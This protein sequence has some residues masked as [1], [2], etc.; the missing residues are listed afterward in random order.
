MAYVV[1]RRN[2]RFEVRESV[3]TPRGPRARSLAGFHVLTEDALSAAAKR[4]SRSF[5]ATAVIAS[6]RRAGAPVHAPLLGETAPDDVASRFLEASRRMSRSMA[7][8]RSALKPADPGAALIDL[9]S[10]VDAVRQSQPPRPPEPLT[11]PVLVRLAQ[12]HRL[13]TAR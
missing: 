8:K 12:D 3:H 2:G 11:F 13:A 1:P 6:A 10:F 4:A 5:D 7:R 9:L